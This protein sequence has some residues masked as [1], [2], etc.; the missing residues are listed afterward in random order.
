VPMIEAI[1]MTVN[2]EIENRMEDSNSTP[3]RHA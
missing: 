2:N 1:Q 3:N